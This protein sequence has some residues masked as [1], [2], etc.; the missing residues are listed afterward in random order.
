VQQQVG[1]GVSITW[2]NFKDAFL[3]HF[4]YQSIQQAKAQEFTDLNQGSLTVDY[5]W[6]VYL[7]LFW[8]KE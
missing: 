1:E 3:K 8:L 4:F 5:T 2:K 6:T 7:S